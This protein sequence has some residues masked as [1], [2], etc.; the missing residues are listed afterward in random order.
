MVFQKKISS[1][2]ESHIPLSIRIVASDYS[3][4]QALLKKQLLE[5]VLFPLEAGLFP[6]LRPS[7]SSF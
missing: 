6:H 2:V 5:R 4:P 3:A 1:S 7:L